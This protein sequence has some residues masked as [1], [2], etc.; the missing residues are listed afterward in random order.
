MC[1]ANKIMII[2]PSMIVDVGV[3]FMDNVSDIRLILKWYTTGHVKFA[4]AM[5][6][7]FLLNVTANIYHWWKWDSNTEKKYT[8]LLIILQLWPI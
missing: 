5:L 4:I 6:I 7:P 1:G 2:L 8:W 3:P